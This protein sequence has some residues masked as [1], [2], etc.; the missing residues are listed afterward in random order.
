MIR[1]IDLLVGEIV[2][3]IGTDGDAVIGIILGAQV[4]VLDDLF[5]QVSQRTGIGEVIK[6]NCKDTIL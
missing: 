4:Q 5:E 3:H 6:N 2:F 1:Q